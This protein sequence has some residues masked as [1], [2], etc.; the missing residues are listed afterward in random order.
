MLEFAK[1]S[2]VQIAIQ[3]V[4]DPRVADYARIKEAL[5]KR[6][7]VFL[8]EGVEVV[9]TLVL[10]SRF[11]ASFVRLGYFLISIRQPMLSVR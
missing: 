11:E 5:A 9:R 3:S 10:R 4:D 7:G 6:R 8:A 1:G 2:A